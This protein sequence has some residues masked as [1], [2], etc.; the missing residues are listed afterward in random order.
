MRQNLKMI[1]VSEEKYWGHYIF[2]ESIF[3]LSTDILGG[4]KNHCTLGID[5]SQTSLF[6]RQWQALRTLPSKHSNMLAV[7]YQVRKERSKQAVLLIKANLQ[8]S[9]LSSQ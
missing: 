5:L 2:K 6:P 9:V 7:K 3:I 8:C 1:L 4:K